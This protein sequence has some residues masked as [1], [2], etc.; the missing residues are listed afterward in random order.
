MICVHL[1]PSADEAIV[2]SDQRRPVFVSFVH[3]VVNQ[4]I[5]Y[6]L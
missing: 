6:R 2:R 5:G 1:R 4:A 3:F